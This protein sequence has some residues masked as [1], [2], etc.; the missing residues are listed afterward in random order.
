MTLAERIAA[1]DRPGEV[2]GLMDMIDLDNATLQRALDFYVQTRNEEGA[3]II[4]ELCALPRE[5]RY[6][7]TGGVDDNLGPS[8]DY[9]PFD[10]VAAALPPSVHA[11]MAT[12]LRAAADLMDIE[13]AHIGGIEVL[14]DVNH[15]I[16]I[17]LISPVVDR[18]GPPNT[19]RRKTVDVALGPAVL[20]EQNM[21]YHLAE[22]SAA[23][24]VTL[25]EAR[26]VELLPGIGMLKE[27]LGREN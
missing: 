25:A 24:R 18:R 4:L 5:E 22:R 2:G 11:H 3:R 12:L 6:A 21:R 9:T 23:L 14:A 20:D 7:A 10:P 17:R 13:P 16:R 1:Y 19:W 26:G 15:G 27:M 8:A